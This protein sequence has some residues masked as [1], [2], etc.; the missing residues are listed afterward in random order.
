MSTN[1]KQTAAWALVTSPCFLFVV[2]FPL[3]SIMQY[4]S[5]WM[6]TYSHWETVC[7]TKQ[8]YDVM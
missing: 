3:L 1:S 7:F 5:H 6:N 8:Y 2:S 4:L